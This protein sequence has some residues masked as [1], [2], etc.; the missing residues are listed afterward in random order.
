MV[1]ISCIRIM[2]YSGR[3]TGIIAQ[4]LDGNLIQILKKPE[5]RYFVVFI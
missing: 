3:N 1:G 5:I 4:I 2:V